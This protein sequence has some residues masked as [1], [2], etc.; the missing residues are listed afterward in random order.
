M[1]LHPE[2]TAFLDL[3][4]AGRQSGR[5][6]LHELDPAA[7]RADFEQASAG[8][9]WPWPQQVER[10]DLSFRARDGAEVG[11]RLYLPRSAE[12]PRQW[13][14]LVYFHGGGFVVGSLDSHDGVCAELAWRT[15]CAVLSVDYRLAPQHRFPTA[16]ED[17]EDALAWLREE[18]AALGLDTERVAFGGDSAGATIATV[19]AIQAARAECPAIRPRLQLLCYPITD[20]SRVSGSAELFDEGYLL[21]A[22]TLEWF[23]SQYQ[24]G[25]EERR[26]W[27]FS[28]LL[29]DEL[30]GCAP[31]FVGLAQFD[32]LLDEGRAYAGR[33]R[34]AGVAVTLREYAGTTHD[35]LRMATV[36]PG[37]GEIHGEIAAQLAAALYP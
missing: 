31:A 27:R 35:F 33:L 8:L 5:K 37:I 4:D 15:P 18:G 19:L 9:R 1:S 16:L 28:P 20:A 3:V 6:A 36:M 23:Y 12:A 17:A 30:S 34:E 32:P 25:V 11:A 10:R 7:A 2:L 22:E 21:E 24:R 26:D 29:C 14:L 13:P